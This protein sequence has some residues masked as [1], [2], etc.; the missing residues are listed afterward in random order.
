MTPRAD[1]HARAV[2]VQRFNHREAS[3]Y[4]PDTYATLCFTV[5]RLYSKA[6]VSSGSTCCRFSGRSLHPKQ[7]FI[8]TFSVRRMYPELLGAALA[9]SSKLTDLGGD[10]RSLMWTSTILFHMIFILVLGDVGYALGRR[11]SRRERRFLKL[12]LRR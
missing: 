1:S 12:L 10:Q 5:L 8:Y 9:V 3:A 2:V 11:Y 7:S 4:Y 6:N